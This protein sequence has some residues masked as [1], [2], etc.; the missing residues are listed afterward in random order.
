[1]DLDVC[2]VCNS[3]RIPDAKPRAEG[4]HSSSIHIMAIALNFSRQQTKRCK[5]FIPSRI[6]QWTLLSFVLAF[7]KRRLGGGATVAALA[8]RVTLYDGSAAARRDAFNDRIM[9]RVFGGVGANIISGSARSEMSR[10]LHEGPSVDNE[11]M[12]ELQVTRPRVSLCG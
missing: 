1:M 11:Y 12:L 5:I 8:T 2:G 10:M 9:R 6:H 4:I 3:P 7:F